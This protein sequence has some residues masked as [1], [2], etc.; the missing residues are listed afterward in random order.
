[1]RLHE[2]DVPKTAFRTPL[3]SFEFLVL[4]FG[5]TNA[6]STFQ[7]LMN[8]VFHD[9]IREGF[10]VVYLDDLLVYSKSREQHLEHLTRI[11]TRLREE[12]LYAKLSKFEFFC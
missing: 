9:F 1:M 6:P 12:K 11:L 3:G 10:V 8:S 7:R 2:S 4:P 5:L